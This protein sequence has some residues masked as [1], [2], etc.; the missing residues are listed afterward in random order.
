[1][2]GDTFATQS[3]YQVQETKK[4]KKKKEKKCQT[5]RII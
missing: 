5:E 2:D 4:K 3:E 1:M